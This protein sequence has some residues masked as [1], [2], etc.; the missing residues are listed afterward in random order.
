MEDKRI[1]VEDRDI[2]ANWPNLLDR[3]RWQLGVG[4]TALIL[5]G[6]GL[7]FTFSF[8]S[9]PELQVEV[10][11]PPADKITVDLAGAVLAPGVYELPGSA[12]LTD[13]LIKAGGLAATADR[14]WVNTYLN[15]AQKLT[16]GQKIYIPEKIQNSNLKT[17][18]D[19]PKVKSN[20][21][22]INSASA[23]ELDTLPGVGPARAQAII[24]NRPYGSIDELLSK[25]KIPASVFEKIKE[26]IAVY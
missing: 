19:S 18:S 7:L 25:A 13:L 21:I 22:N 16:D 2:K 11:N 24:A 10:L 9:H 3:Y 17:Q 15:L 14:V 8:R 23:A 20:Q 5:I 12:R 6:L 1:R 26:Q 4:L